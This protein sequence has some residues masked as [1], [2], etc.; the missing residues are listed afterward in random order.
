MDDTPPLPS[1]PCLDSPLRGDQEEVVESAEEESK[2][3]EVTK[4]KEQWALCGES[5]WH[6]CAVSR[7]QLIAAGLK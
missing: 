6:G 2:E 3:A 4:E 5:L 7:C 1:E